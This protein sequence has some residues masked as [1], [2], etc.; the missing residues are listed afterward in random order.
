M[1]SRLCIAHVNYLLEWLHRLNT[2][3]DMCGEEV[4][5]ERCTIR[6]LSGAEKQQI[7]FSDLILLYFP[8][9][10]EHELSMDAA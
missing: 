7:V 6:K 10:I 4:T 5:G 9:L 2:Q 8:G 1:K 3:K